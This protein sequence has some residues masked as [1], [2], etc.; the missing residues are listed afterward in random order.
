LERIHVHAV[1]EIDGQVVWVEMHE[2]EVTHCVRSWPH[3]IRSDACSSRYHVDSRVLANT[4]STADCSSGDTLAPTDARSCRSSSH[5]QL[6]LVTQQKVTAGEASCAL[7][8]F[9]RLL[10]GV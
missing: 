6:L 1:C 9:E 8:T 4:I 10:F 3:C 5:M 7:G 2:I